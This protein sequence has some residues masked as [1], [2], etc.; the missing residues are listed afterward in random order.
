MM[1]L[2]ICLMGHCVA[3]GKRVLLVCNIRSE[4]ERVCTA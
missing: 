3:P 1:P 2:E 4:V